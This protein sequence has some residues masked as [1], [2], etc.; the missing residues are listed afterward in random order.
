MEAALAAYWHKEEEETLRKEQQREKN[1]RAQLTQQVHFN[2]NLN[3]STCDVII[4]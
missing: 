1:R 4:I 2:E 3:D